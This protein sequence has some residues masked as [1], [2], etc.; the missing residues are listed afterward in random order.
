MGECHPDAHVKGASGRN[1]IAPI[2]I[3][4]A[5]NSLATFS[6]NSMSQMYKI[7][8]NEIPVI[9]REGNPKDAAERGD[10]HHPVY[11]F[12]EQKA[13]QNAF[14]RVELG[15]YLRSLTI[16]GEDAKEIRK[17]LFRDYTIIEAAGG[18]VV[19]QEKQILMIYRHSMWD[20]PKGKLDAGEQP[21][22]AAVR[23]VE[24]ETGI[25]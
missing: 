13:I 15:V 1:W 5:E 20:L 18:V 8:M 17:G 22:A 16:I 25:G 2:C 9:I 10:K 4:F 14:E 11:F 23:E 24:E 7:F 3:S 12:N 19:N 21:K 6:S